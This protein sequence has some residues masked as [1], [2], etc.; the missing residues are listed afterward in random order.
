MDFLW[1]LGNG[2]G[3]CHESS[4]ILQGSY[5]YDVHY[6]MVPWPLLGFLRLDPCFRRCKDF[7]RKVMI[8]K[9]QK[10]V[11]TW[12][13]AFVWGEGPDLW[14]VSVWQTDTRSGKSILARTDLVQ[15]KNE[16][17]R[18]PSKT[19]AKKDVFFWGGSGKERKITRRKTAGIKDLEAKGVSVTRREGVIYCGA[20][21][22]W[23]Q[24]HLSFSGDYRRLRQPQHSVFQRPKTPRNRQFE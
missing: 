10:H 7:P 6:Q 9:I 15:K 20:K 11:E 4:F 8:Y 22:F 5:A 2:S 13:F 16:H 24:K 23:D 14:D 12:S 3:R 19:V 21:T 1:I 17:T 18:K